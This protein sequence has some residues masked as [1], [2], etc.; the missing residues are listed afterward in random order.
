MP[1]ESKLGVLPRG[2]RWISRPYISGVGQ[3]WGGTFDTPEEAEERSK[4]LIGEHAT[5]PPKQET[6]HSFCGRWVR[7]FPRPKG[8][9]N[10]KYKAEA[11]RFA[12]E[13]DPNDRRRLHEYGVTEALAYGRKHGEPA[14][15]ILRAM[16]GDARREGLL[17]KDAENPFSSLGIAKG[18][19][20]KDLV[21]ITEDE[22]DLICE[23]I[24]DAHSKDFAPVFHCIV[25]WAAATT[26]RPSEI[27]GLDRP[28]VDLVA[29]IVR[30]ERQFYKRRVQSP[31]NDS[32]RRLPY[33]PPRAEAAFRRLP[34][35]VPA[36]I[37]PETGNE[38]LF[39]GKQGQRITQPALSLYWDPVRI[40]FEAQ[41]TPHRRAE[42]RAPRHP[43]HPKM[44]F[45]ELRHFGATQMAELG[46]EDWVGAEMMG[47]TD[48]GK[49]FRDTYS[50]PAN[51]VAGERLKRAF[52][53]NVRELWPIDGD[54]KEA[55]G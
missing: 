15:S 33:I 44:D 31:K 22:L 52:G 8:S 35:R 6:I 49:L 2:D 30:I 5:R 53:Q 25:D 14:I 11:K 18:R 12:A 34:R 47:H 28:D 4:E 17:R 9:T 41:L 19:G 43:D 32:P 42:L 51:K 13:A 24:Y 50:H 10:D 54:A 36:P 29:S 20:R 16:F 23:I 26:M 46:V 45:Y 37:C 3:K 1:K 38:I 7:D 21:A 55:T 48:G 40:A 39:Y 27:F